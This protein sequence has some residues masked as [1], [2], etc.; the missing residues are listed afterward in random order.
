MTSNIMTAVDQERIADCV[1]R[2]GWD[3]FVVHDVLNTIED[4]YAIDP[5][6]GAFLLEVHLAQARR[7]AH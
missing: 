1:R 7:R 5:E 2:E 4:E 3:D 6:G